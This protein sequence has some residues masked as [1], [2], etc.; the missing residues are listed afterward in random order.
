MHQGAVLQQEGTG[1]QDTEGK[2]TEFLPHNC[3]LCAQFV[4]GA[5]GLALCAFS[6]L[7]LSACLLSI[8][9]AKQT[10]AFLGK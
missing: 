10:N 1:H 3:F 6:H 5:P 7:L 9:R 4:A 8:H 2:L